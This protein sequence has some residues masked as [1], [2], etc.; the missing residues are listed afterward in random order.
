MLYASYEKKENGKYVE[1]WRTENR[2]GIYERLAQALISKKLHHCT[3]YKR[4]TDN[5]NYD[6]TRTIV[7]YDDIGGR[8][9]F[10]IESR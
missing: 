4:I 2:E 8:N 7:M 10:R 3:Y 6:G 5:N 9:I 1:T